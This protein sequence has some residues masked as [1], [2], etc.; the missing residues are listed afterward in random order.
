[1]VLHHLQHLQH[2]H[3][4]LRATALLM[5][6][7]TTTPVPPSTFTRPTVC[8][9]LWLSSSFSS[10]SRQRWQSVIGATRRCV[11]YSSS[12]RRWRS[13]STCTVRWW[14]PTHAS[15]APSR[16]CRSCW[17][18]CAPCR[19]ISTLWLRSRSPWARAVLTVRST[20]GTRLPAGPTSRSSRCCAP[21]A[22]TCMAFCTT[23]SGASRA[24]LRCSMSCNRFHRP[25][26]SCSTPSLSATRY[27]RASPTCC[28]PRRPRASP[29]SCASCSLRSNK[30]SGS[31]PTSRSTT[32]TTTTT[33]SLVPLVLL[34]RP[35]SKARS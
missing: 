22:R 13:L 33:M 35:S 6:I 18:S 11:L 15:S 5:T 32:T 3:L 10:S 1:M 16:P 8:K 21:Y 4:T 14:T 29:R 17:R 31:A 19:T 24:S 34:P 9:V 26:P 23:P 30:H 20:C 28:R 7:P 27:V 12:A 2:L 25:T